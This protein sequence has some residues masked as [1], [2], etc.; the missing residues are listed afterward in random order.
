MLDYPFSRYQ[1]RQGGS[2]S[3]TMLYLKCYSPSEGFAIYDYESF[4]SR[5]T[6]KLIKTFNKSG[7]WIVT[8]WL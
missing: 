1:H 5:I 3:N 4:N 2:L 6:R 7:N 8:L